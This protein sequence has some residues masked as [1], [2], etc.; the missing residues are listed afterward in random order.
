MSVLSHRRS[1]KQQIGV[2]DTMARSSEFD[3]DW[4]FRRFV[5]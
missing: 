1:R 4:C 2:H 3:E 5:L